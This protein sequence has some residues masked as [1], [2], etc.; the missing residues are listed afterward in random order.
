M[1]YLKKPEEEKK[2]TGKH[3]DWYKNVDYASNLCEIYNAKVEDYQAGYWEIKPGNKRFIIHLFSNG[4]DIR[5][6]RNKNRI[7]H[8]VEYN[9]SHQDFKNQVNDAF[10]QAEIKL[11]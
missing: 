9:Q 1:G 2:A 5:Y 10:T 7:S 3:W 6:D 8:S 11:K 4:I